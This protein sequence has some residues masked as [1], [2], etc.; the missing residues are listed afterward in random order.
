MIR[1]LCYELYK[2]DWK[3]DMISKEREMDSLKSYYEYMEDMAFEEY[4]YNDY[5]EEF[6]YNEQLYV[7]YEEF[8]E[9]EYLETNYIKHLLKNDKLFK[10]YL[11]DLW[12]VSSY[13]EDTEEQLDYYINENDC[14]VG[15][16]AYLYNHED[17]KLTEMEIVHIIPRT[18][19]ME[20]Y[21]RLTGSEDVLLDGEEEYFADTS[22]EFI[23][24]YDC[25]LVWF[26]Y[27]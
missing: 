11:E 12:I 1:Q 22:A 18:A 20:F 16:K 4:T 8:L 6:G 5:L 23:A 25:Y 14:N 2:T 9:N 13:N 27:C 10:L 7:C 15:D 26:K 3:H 24:D 19:D 21:D 17:G